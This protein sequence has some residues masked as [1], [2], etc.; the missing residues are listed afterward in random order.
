MDHLAYL[1]GFA[2][3]LESVEA[4]G[5]VTPLRECHYEKRQRG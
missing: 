2:V 5:T 3:R 4:D 1:W